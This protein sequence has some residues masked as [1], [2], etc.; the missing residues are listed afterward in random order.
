[1]LTIEKKRVK[2][3]ARMIKLKDIGSS[4]RK[5]KNITYKSSKTKNRKEQQFQLQMTEMM[6]GQPLF[7]PRTSFDSYDS[8]SPESSSSESCYCFHPAFFI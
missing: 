3:E 8:R 1:M 5:E 7:T 6:C 4:S 2:L